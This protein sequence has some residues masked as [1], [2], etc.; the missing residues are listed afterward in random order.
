LPKLQF[1]CYTVSQTLLGFPFKQ[2]R[3]SKVQ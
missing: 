3:L 1:E 2:L